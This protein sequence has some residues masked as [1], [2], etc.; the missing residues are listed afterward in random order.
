MNDNKL[1]EESPR[2]HRG[3]RHRGH[4]HLGKTG[5]S[6]ATKP[7]SSK[8]QVEKG[9]PPAPSSARVQLP[10]EAELEAQIAQEV[11]EAFDRAKVNVKGLASSSGVER[12]GAEKDK[13]SDAAAGNKRKASSDIAKSVVGVMAGTAKNASAPPAK[14]AKTGKEEMK[15]KYDE[16]GR[17]RYGK[18]KES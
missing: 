18:K 10:D 7:S 11:K 12:K 15:K 3:R 2:T 5:E 9:P 1:Y 4:G 13:M 8:E 16:V 17:E 14:I 6:Q